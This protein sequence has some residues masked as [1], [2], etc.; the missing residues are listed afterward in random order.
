MSV[1]AGLNGINLPEKVIKRFLKRKECGMLV[2][3]EQLDL[4]KFPEQTVGVLDS[5][6]KTSRLQEDRRDSL[7]ENVA[8]SFSQLQA[9]LETS[10]KKID[11]AI[12]SLRT[13]KTYLV[14]T[15]DL[16]FSSFK[17]NWPKSGTT[18][19][20]TFLIQQKSSLSTGSVSSLSDTLEEDVPEKYF[21]SSKLTE[22]LISGQTQRIPLPPDMEKLKGQDRTLLKV[23]RR[24]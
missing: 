24:K 1:L 15:E 11:P 16:T 3:S 13:L 5:H 19:N 10:K 12:Y 14:L 2:I 23:N 6:A 22:K 20:G 18:S 17:L 9:L 4:L 21:L 7:P 8:L